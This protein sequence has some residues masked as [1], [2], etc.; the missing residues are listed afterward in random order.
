MTTFRNRDN[1]WGR[2][3]SQSQHRTVLPHITV[4]STEVLQQQ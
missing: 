2:W 4:L 1:S 3:I